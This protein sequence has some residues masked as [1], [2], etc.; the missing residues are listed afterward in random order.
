MCT[1]VPSE[2]CTYSSLGD[3]N[4]YTPGTIANSQRTPSKINQNGVITKVRICGTSGKM[5]HLTYWE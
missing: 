1:L 5:R 2:E 4:M 3:S